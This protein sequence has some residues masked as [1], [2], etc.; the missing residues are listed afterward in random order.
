MLLKRPRIAAPSPVTTLAGLEAQWRRLFELR[1]MLG[2]VS[3]DEPEL[4]NIVK[5]GALST[6]AQQAQEQQPNPFAVYVDLDSQ[7]RRWG[8]R[9]SVTLSDIILAVQLAGGAVET[10]ISATPPAVLK[11]TKINDIAAWSASEVAGLLGST[12]SSSTQQRMRQQNDRNATYAYTGPREVCGTI[13]SVTNFER[14]S[15]K[16]ED[17]LDPTDEGLRAEAPRYSESNDIAE[18]VSNIKEGLRDYY[19]EGGYYAS[20]GASE[21]VKACQV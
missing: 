5:R 3:N 20:E 4:V 2:S 12:F 11:I 1:E 17:G 13:A 21:S 18:A 10:G 16:G 14:T 7:L 9:G 15:S 8:N 19:A 6:K